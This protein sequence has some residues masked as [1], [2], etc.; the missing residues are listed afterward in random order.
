[1]PNIAHLAVWTGDITRLQEF[2]TRF[3]GAVGSPIY[4]NPAKQFR[5]CF[6]SFSSGA[7]LELMNRPGLLAPGQ[8]C[9]CFGYAHLAISTGSEKEVDELTERLRSASFRIVGEPR[10]TGDGYYE[11]VVLDP[12]GNLVEI[13]V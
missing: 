8:G 12:D 2:Y 10:H 13:T 11:S 3:F 7:R 1:M 5:S 4:H 9:E 6:L